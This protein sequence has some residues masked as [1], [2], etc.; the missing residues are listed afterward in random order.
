MSGTFL[1]ENGNSAGSLIEWM[2]LIYLSLKGFVVFLSM[3][4]EIS[5]FEKIDFEDI[6]IQFKLLIEKWHH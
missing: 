4:V 2:C 6:L 3:R 1:F 5:D